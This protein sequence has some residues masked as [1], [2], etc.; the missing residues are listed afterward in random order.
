MAHSRSQGQQGDE[1]CAHAR[2]REDPPL[3]ACNHPLALGN[4][5]N[6]NYGLVWNIFHRHGMHSGGDSSQ[7]LS[8][9]A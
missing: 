5:A 6:K 3:L 9:L 1:R 7:G 2:L 4:Q 8:L